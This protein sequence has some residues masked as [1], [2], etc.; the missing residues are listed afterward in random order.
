MFNHTT[1]HNTDT[2]TDSTKLPYTIQNNNHN[3]NQN[4]VVRHLVF[5]DHD[6]GTLNRAR[7]NYHATRTHLRNIQQSSSSSSAAA[8]DDSE[9]TT[10][11]CPSK[12]NNDEKDE[13]TVVRFQPLH[14]G[15]R[16]A[17]NG[18]LEG[19]R[20]PRTDDE[21]ITTTT[22]THKHNTLPTDRDETIVGFDLVLGSDLVYCSDVVEPL[23]TTAA[24]LMFPKTKDDDCVSAAENDDRRRRRMERTSAFVMSQSFPYEIQTEEEIDRMCHLLKLKRVILRDD[25]GR[26]ECA[27]GG[28]GGGGGC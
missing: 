26:G 13:E 2:N 1:T 17:I 16:E 9:R 15:D 5:S 11:P 19:M 7:D 10:A 24:R 14:W 18:I 27:E 28:G 21:T 23:F 6:P 8:E 4:R 20:H 22:T 12:D 3:Q 25:L